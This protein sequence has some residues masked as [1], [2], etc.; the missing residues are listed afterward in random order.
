MIV[1]GPETPAGASP[2]REDERYIRIHPSECPARAKPVFLAI[3][4]YQPATM[5]P[6]THCGPSGR[7]LKRPLERGGA[8]F[9]RRHEPEADRQE[10]NRE[11]C[12]WRD[13][14]PCQP[15]AGGSRLAWRE[16]TWRAVHVQKHEGDLRSPLSHSCCMRDYP[17]R[18]GIT[19]GIN[20]GAVPPRSSLRNHRSRYPHR[21]FA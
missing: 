10:D 18:W 1:T 13:P 3:E 19:R 14:G 2:S 15:V 12:P 9:L 4:S 21:R 11:P 17:H 5:H 7:P 16:H 6:P 8:F 20:V